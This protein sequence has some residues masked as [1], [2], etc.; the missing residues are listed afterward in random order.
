MWLIQS[1]ALVTGSDPGGGGAYLM[2]WL[3][4]PSKRQ[5]RGSIAASGHFV[6]GVQDAWD[7]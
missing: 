1:N 2:V 7:V 3:Y 4:K 5:P 6:T